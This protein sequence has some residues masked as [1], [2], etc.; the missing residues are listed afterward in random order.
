MT[1]IATIRMRDLTE[2]ARRTLA[3]HDAGAIGALECA[4][5]AG[6]VSSLALG[7]PGRPASSYSAARGRAAAGTTPRAAPA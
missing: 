6:G 7:H 3:L 1:D 4:A 5:V 2:Q